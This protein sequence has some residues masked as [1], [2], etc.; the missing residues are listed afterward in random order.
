MT[1]NAVN[2]Y[3]PSHI[4]EWKQKIS[5]AKKARIMLKDF[6]KAYGISP[7]KWLIIKN[8]INDKELTS[9]PKNWVGRDE[10][11]T[12]KKKRNTAEP[13]YSKMPLLDVPP[14]ISDKPLFCLLLAF[15]SKEQALNVMGRYL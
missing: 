3:D 5:E 1:N 15:D 8:L 7:N 11:H 10:V 9:F 13:S 4:E 2:I 6:M 14:P 12:R